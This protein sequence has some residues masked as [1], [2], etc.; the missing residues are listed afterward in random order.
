MHGLMSKKKKK[1]TQAYIQSLYETL[2]HY[3]PVYSTHSYYI[4]S[5]VLNSLHSP[6]T[7]HLSVP[8]CS[9]ASNVALKSS[10][11]ALNDGTYEKFLLMKIWELFVCWSILPKIQQFIV[12]WPCKTLRMVLYKLHT[13]RH[14]IRLWQRQSIVDILI[15]HDVSSFISPNINGWNVK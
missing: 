12:L 15:L 11:L 4:Y 10:S 14:L 5:R 8:F 6:Q 3:I 9:P 1:I 2:S 13:V 7:D